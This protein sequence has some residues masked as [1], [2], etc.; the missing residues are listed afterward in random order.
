MAIEKSVWP[1]LTG[2]WLLGIAGTILALP[3]PAEGTG[4][5]LCL[6][7]PGAGLPLVSYNFGCLSRFAGTFGGTGAVICLLGGPTLYILLALLLR[8]L[9]K[10]IP[11]PLSL[12]IVFALHYGI[13]AAAI[14]IDPGF[15]AVFNGTSHV[16]R[17]ITWTMPYRAVASIGLIA[18]VQILAM[19]F[20]RQVVRSRDTRGF[21]P[22]V[23]ASAHHSDKPRV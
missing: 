10:R 15:G 21:E 8:F 5:I 1:S 14:S 2:A 23:C 7:A 4:V 3:A 13:A 17:R 9:V 12:L 18:V 22:V 6:V 19:W 11:I 16:L 20:A